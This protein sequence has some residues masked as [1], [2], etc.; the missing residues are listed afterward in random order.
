MRIEIRVRAAGTRRWF[1]GLAIVGLSQM[2]FA[3][4]D[5][6]NTASRPAPFP[7]IS[8]PADPRAVAD[9]FN[10]ALTTGNKDVVLAILAP[11]VLIVESG[12]AETSA[13]EYAGHHMPA[14]MEFLA[15]LE[16]ELISQQVGGEG[17]SAWVATRSR[18]HGWFKGENVDL[19]STETLVMLKSG[20]AWR[21]THIH[22]SSVPHRAPKP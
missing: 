12:M 10:R 8:A 3:H 20:G 15:S 6:E 17:K 14:D 5:T 9:L 16:R 4:G 18:L 13:A 11:D 22:W 7:A 2:S 1:I 19:D 21:I